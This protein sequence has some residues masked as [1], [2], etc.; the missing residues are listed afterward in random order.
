MLMAK[1][2]PKGRPS[3]PSTAQGKRLLAWR[4]RLGLTQAQAAAKVRV[5]LRTWAGYEAGDV[6]PGPVKL[7]IDLF[8]KKN[9]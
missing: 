4:Q 1:K 6:I 3:A 8:D 9:A 7:L 2:R 5:S